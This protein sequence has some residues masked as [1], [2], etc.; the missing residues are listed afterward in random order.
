[1]FILVLFGYKQ[2]KVFTID[3]LG[4]TLIDCIWNTSLK[5]INKNL[6]LKEEQHTKDQKNASSKIKHNEARI[7]EISQ[8]LGDE[9]EQAVKK[10]D[11]KATKAPPP[12]KGKE[13]VPNNPL[14]AERM[15]LQKENEK[16]T[17]AVA[18]YTDKLQKLRAAVEKFKGIIIKLKTDLNERFI[19]GTLVLELFDKTGERKFIKTK[20]DLRANEFLS[21]KATYIIGYLQQTQQPDEEETPFALEYEGFIARTY[22]EDIGAVDEPL[23][24][25]QVKKDD[26]KKKGKK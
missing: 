20:L 5:E 12:K 26:K 7:K 10:D 22:D 21:E 13:V 1:M 15:D 25:P 9:A 2:F 4:Q 6:T 23:L 16:L 3:C 11:K 8:Q 18:K 19:N 17:D 24:A 14:E